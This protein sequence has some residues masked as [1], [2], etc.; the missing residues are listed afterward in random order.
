MLQKWKNSVNAQC[1]WKLCK[2]K[3][4]FLKRNSSFRC[5]IGNRVKNISRNEFE[6][7][8]HLSGKQGIPESENNII[9]IFLF[10]TR[11]KPRF[12]SGT[13]Y[14]SLQNQLN[15]SR[16]CTFSLILYHCGPATG[17]EEVHVVFFTWLDQRNFWRLSW[18]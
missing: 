14:P 7:T 9:P 2:Y 6:I 13:G 18:E 17:E 1:L 16:N 8:T 5:S 12:F 3:F 11:T 15:N 10:T 4:Y